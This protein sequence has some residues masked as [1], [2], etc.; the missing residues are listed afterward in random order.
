[1]RDGRALSGGRIPLP[2]NPNLGTISTMPPEGYE[3]TDA[4]TY[5]RG[6]DQTDQSQGAGST[7][8]SH[9]LLFFGDPQPRSATALL[10]TR[11]S[12]AA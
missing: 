8:G 4:S 11:A 5:G 6:F 1:M 7:P 9:A 12:S 3:P 10:P 2:F